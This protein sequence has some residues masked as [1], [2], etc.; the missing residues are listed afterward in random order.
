ME[1]K[2]FMTHCGSGW[3]V[4]AEEVEFV[5]ET[6]TQ[7]KFRRKCGKIIKA[8][9]QIWACKENCHQVIGEDYKF[10]K[11]SLRDV[12]TVQRKNYITTYLNK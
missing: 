10:Y 6:A 12:E 1:K 4:F 5:G 11:I 7:L 9:K 2:W 3:T 8:R